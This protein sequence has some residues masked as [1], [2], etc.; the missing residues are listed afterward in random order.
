MR[1]R[2]NPDLFRQKGITYKEAVLEISK[3]LE[4]RKAMYLIVQLHERLRFA[5]R[6]L[7]N[8][9][10]SFSNIWIFDVHVVTDRFVV[11]DIAIFISEKL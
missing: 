5:E 7:E 6:Q 1:E 4:I 8:R 3:S 9:S 10:N 2:R 11:D